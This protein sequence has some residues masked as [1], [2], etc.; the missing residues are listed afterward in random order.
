MSKDRYKTKQLMQTDK[1]E[2]T[3]HLKEGHFLL[4]RLLMIMIWILLINNEND[5]TSHL[6]AS[7]GLHY[8]RHSTLCRSEVIKHSSCVRL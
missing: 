3:L 1:N 6:S 4:K 5:K 7:A 8:S 2:S